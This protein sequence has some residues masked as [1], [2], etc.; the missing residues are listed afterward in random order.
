[1]KINSNM[2]RPIATCVCIHMYAD[3]MYTHPYLCVNKTGREGECRDRGY[4][5]VKIQ[6]AIQDECTCKMKQ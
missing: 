1:M 6:T 2:H 5:C 3:K 4:E